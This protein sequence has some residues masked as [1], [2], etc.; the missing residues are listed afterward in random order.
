MFFKRMV[1]YEMWHVCIR[2]EDNKNESESV[3]GKYGSNKSGEKVVKHE[4]E[5]DKVGEAGR[6]RNSTF[7]KFE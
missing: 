1:A 7:V 6:G 4:S 3:H 5:L 2:I